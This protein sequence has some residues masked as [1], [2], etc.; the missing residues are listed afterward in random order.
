M[1]RPLNRNWGSRLSIT[2]FIVVDQ[3]YYLANFHGHKR[4]LHT[5]F[6]ATAYTMSIAMDLGLSNKV[7]V[8][9]AASGGL[10]KAIA[11]EFAAEGARVVLAARGAEKLDAAVR[12]I[13]AATDNAPIPKRADCTV[14]R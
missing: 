7:V 5:R 13:A 1:S 8:V 3:E 10:G 9:T 11:Q 12:E 6:W 4:I 2:P 14:E